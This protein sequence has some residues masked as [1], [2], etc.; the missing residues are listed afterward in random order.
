MFEKEQDVK[1]E[2]NTYIVKNQWL[3]DKVL[4]ER[5]LMFSIP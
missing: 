1:E 4:K 2:K 5:W 3:P